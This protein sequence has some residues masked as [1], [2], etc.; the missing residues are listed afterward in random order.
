M[1]VLKIATSELTNNMLFVDRKCFCLVHVYFFFYKNKTPLWI[2]NLFSKFNIYKFVCV[3]FF[4][5][6]VLFVFLQLL[7]NLN[8]EEI[9]SPWQSKAC[10]H[11]NLL[12]F[13]L[14][15]VSCMVVPYIFGIETVKGP[16]IYRNIQII[17]FILKVILTVCIIYIRWL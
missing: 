10:K 5:L 6:F 1:R 7:F 17:T 12:L 11:C 16:V 13:C 9:K 4:F 2:D 14:N 8:S 15:P 3:C